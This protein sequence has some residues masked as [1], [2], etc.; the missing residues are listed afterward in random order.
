MSTTYRASCAVWQTILM[1]AYIT[2]GQELPE[3]ANEMR[4]MCIS[5]C[6]VGEAA[7]LHGKLGFTSQALCLRRRMSALVHCSRPWS[8]S[9]RELEGSPYAGASPNINI[10]AAL[11]L[12]NKSFPSNHAYEAPHVGLAQ[13]PLDQRWSPSGWGSEHGRSRTFTS[14]KST[15]S[16]RLSGI[17]RGRCRLRSGSSIHS[18]RQLRR[19]L[20]RPPLRRPPT[21]H[22]LSRR[23]LHGRQQSLVNRTFDLWT[24]CRPRSTSGRTPACTL[25]RRRLALALPAARGGPM[26]TGCTPA[27]PITRRPARLLA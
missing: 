24:R 14:R 1:H 13:S 2:Y 5:T 11:W 27:R 16:F 4:F 19:P 23:T 22:T 7:A 18:D 12:T 10:E 26:G 21:S 3:Q 20:N 17:T 25:T 6:R 15:T 8:K 9:V